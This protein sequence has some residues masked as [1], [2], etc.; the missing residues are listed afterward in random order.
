MSATSRTTPC[1]STGASTRLEHARA[2][3][4]VA[5]LVGG[6]DDELATPQVAAALAAGIVLTELRSADGAGLEDLF[7]SLTGT[8]PTTDSL[9]STQTKENAA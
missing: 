3:L 6:G 1:T 8:G 7:L 5:E 2:F 4:E 9:H